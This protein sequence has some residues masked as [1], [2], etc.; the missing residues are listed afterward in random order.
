MCGW[1]EIKEAYEAPNSADEEHI[2]RIDWVKRIAGD[3]YN[4]FAE[5]DMSSINSL[6]RWRNDWRIKQMNK[7][8]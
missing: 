7:G 6:D 8:K 2:E 4:P 3:A 5:P 1:D